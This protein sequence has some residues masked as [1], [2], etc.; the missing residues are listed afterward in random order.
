MIFDLGGITEHTGI[1]QF[2]NMGVGNP[3]A[4]NHR[5]YDVT[6]WD[7]YSSWA[8]RPCPIGFDRFQS[9]IDDDDVDAK[10]LWLHAI[11]THPLAYAEHRLAHFNQSTYFLIREGPNF[12]AWSQSVP[13]PWN[14]RV[15]PNA[16]ISTVTWIVNAAARTPLGWPIFWIGLSLAVLILASAGSASA[17]MIAIAASAFFYGAGYLIFSVASGM[18]YHFW[19]ISGAAVATLLI[20]GELWPRRRQLPRAA[21]AVAALVAVLPTLLAAAARVVL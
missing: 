9:L 10:A 3:V 19:T 2:P 14:F 8:K 6:G 4:V 12:T 13:N 1:S 20:A 7:S 16:I 17:E 11:R 18:R 21:V 15:A 5:C